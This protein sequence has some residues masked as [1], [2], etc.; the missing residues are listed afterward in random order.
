MVLFHAKMSVSVSTWGWLGLALILFLSSFGPLGLLWL[1]VYSVALIL[2]FFLMLFIHGKTRYTTWHQETV[3]IDM[4]PPSVGLAKLAEDVKKEKPKYKMDK[5]MTGSFIIDD[6]LQEILDYTYRDYIHTWY[7]RISDDEEFGYDIRLTLQRVIIAFSERA[8]DVD[9]VPYITTRLVDDFAS[10]LRLYRRALQK[11]METRKDDTKPPADL[12]SIFFDLETEME[13]NMCR[14]MICTC[15][16]SERQYLQDLSEVLLFLLLPPGDFHNKPFRYIAREVL[17]NGIFQKTIDMVSDPDYIN[18]KVSWLCKDTSFSNETFLTALKTSDNIEELQAVKEKV[19]QDIVRQRS[20]DT[21]GDDD[22]FIKQQLSSLMFVQAICETRIKRLV[23]GVDESEGSLGF[24][25]RPG[26]KL[27]NLPF[28]VVLNNN[29]ALSYFIEFMTSIGAQAYLFFYLTIECYKTSA[30]QLISASLLAENDMEKPDLESLRDS[31]IRIFNQ[32][33][34]EKASPRLKMDEKSVYNLWDQIQNGQPSDT[35][36]DEVQAR[37]CDYIQE[38]GKY[39]PAFRKSQL[40]IKLLAELDLLCGKESCQK[41]DDGLMSEDDAISS[42]SKSSSLQARLMLLSER[43]NLLQSMED[44]ASSCDSL[45]STES[46]LNLKP[47]AP[48]PTRT[49][50]ISANIT[51]TGICQEHGKAYAVYL[52]TVTK[53]YS[54]NT[55]EIWDVYRRYSDFH[56]F[57]MI[58]QDKFDTLPGISLPTKKV[59]NN[60]SKDFVEKR[61]VGLNA[62]LQTL[63]SAPVL[64]SHPGLFDLVYTFLEAIHWEHEKSQLA[65]KMDTFVNP[66]KNSVRNVGNMVRSMPDNFVDGVA[67]MS[68]GIKKIP[69]NMLDGVGKILNV[70]GDLISSIL[71][72]QL[73]ITDTEP[74]MPPP[75]PVKHDLV[76]SGKVGKSLETENDEENIPMRIMLLLMDEVFDLR[77][78]NQW[79]RSRIV[80]ILRQIIKT[81]FGDSINRDAFWP[82]G[83]LAETHP[84]RDHSTVM[85]TRLV[86]RSK[87]F[88]SISD[89]IRRLVGT[90]TTR[91][92]VIRIFNMFQHRT[93]NKRLVYVIL[94]GILET[95][96]PDHKFPE[97]FRTIHS[98]SP[99]VKKEAERN[100]NISTGVTV[101]SD[102]YGLTKRK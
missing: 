25:V 87:M 15:E 40:Y 51:N 4:V 82:N 16:E 100:A 27:Y 11:L 18:Q 99:R 39:F 47:M 84:T 74:A 44:L 75:V 9:L 29:V 12:E 66:L 101:V 33:L 20:K 83:I 30:E 7:R 97:V 42:S 77:N 53:H 37:T 94:E 54:D 58:L 70:K 61:R 24:E 52:I 56:D 10:H 14:D 2:G 59:I 3:N 6:V 98:R 45:S 76:D 55:E 89:D 32:Y 38:N 31:A 26:Q 96:F 22:T 50:S 62:Y 80:A 95:L 13:N 72:S 43:W 48:L 46:K 65:K 71:P 67:K 49:F 41:L 68:G 93:L 8:K 86:C 102:Q 19:D 5:R 91:Q 63:L 64:K 78:R 69:N 81:M 1:L 92:G 90:E 21:G 28:D 57:H 35:I 17:V 34:S 23:E 79:F 85:R 73:Q 88:G 60:T 36:F